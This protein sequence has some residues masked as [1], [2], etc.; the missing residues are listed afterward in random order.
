MDLMDNFEKPKGYVRSQFK[1][2]EEKVK[3]REETK[4]N[5]NNLGEKV[6]EESKAKQEIINNLK[7]KVRE[8]E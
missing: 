1:Y 4:A 5:I 6:R 8:R 7:E 3:E 2:L